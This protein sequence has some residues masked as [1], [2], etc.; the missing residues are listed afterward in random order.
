MGNHLP[1]RGGNPIPEQS[2]HVGSEHGI[3]GIRA[4]IRAGGRHEQRG[5]LLWLV[6]DRPRQRRLPR[7]LYEASLNANLQQERQLGKLYG[8]PGSGL[9]YSAFGNTA[10]QAGQQGESALARIIAYMRLNVISF[11][12]LYGSTRTASPSTRTSTACWSA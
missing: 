2:A 11:W 9:D 4:P 3:K 6:H 7:P 10:V 8:D 5:L 12:S 1:T